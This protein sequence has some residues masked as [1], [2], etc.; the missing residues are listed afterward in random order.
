MAWFK[1]C[2]ARAAGANPDS[3]FSVLRQWDHGMSD[4]GP[5]GKAA[6]GLISSKIYVQT[7]AVISFYSVSGSLPI[8]FVFDHPTAPWLASIIALF[9][10][11]PSIYRL[12]SRSRR[13]AFRAWIM[14]L[15]Y[16]SVWG[17]LKQLGYGRWTKLCL[18]AIAGLPFRNKGSIYICGVKALTMRLPFI[19][20]HPTLIEDRGGMGK[21]TGQLQQDRLAY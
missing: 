17:S 12:I 14:D 9:T 19:S 3:V 8:A 6:C 16:S 13:E 10:P 7:S 11:V 2:C 18:D 5:H 4:M 1:G 20:T 15:L 21:K